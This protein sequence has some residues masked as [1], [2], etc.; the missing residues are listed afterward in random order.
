MVDRDDTGTGADRD[1]VEKLAESF[2]ERHRRGERPQISEYAEK[3]P[4][5]AGRIRELFPALLMVEQA[6]SAEIAGA[7]AA[8]APGKAEPARELGD[9]TI[10]RRIGGGGMG[11]VYEARQESLGRHV[12]LKVL[13]YQSLPAESHLERFRR[14]AQAAAQ[15]HHTNIVPVYAVGEHEGLHYYAM[16]LIQGQ[17]LE[18]VIEELRQLRAAGAAA[19][20]AQPASG[21]SI[22][23][24][25]RS[26]IFERDGD[27]GARASD[28]APQAKDGSSTAALLDGDSGAGANASIRYARSVARLGI[29]A[30]SALAYAHGEGVLHRDV[31]PSNLLLDAKGALWITDFG[32]AKTESSGALTR[33]G[34]IVGTLSYMAP[35]RL[36]GW[37]DPRSDIYALG[38]TLYELLTLTRTF[39]CPDRNR[40]MRKI[41]EEKPA[42]PRAIDPRIP[43]DLETIVLKAIEKEPARRY[44]AAAQ[45][46][47]DLRSF[48]EGRPIRARRSTTAER[49]W[50]WCRRNPV[51]GALAA[52]SVLLLLAIA[53]GAVV[54]AIRL[55]DEHNVSLEYLEKARI[56]ET[57]AAA[58]AADAKR[59]LWD[60]CLAHARA[61]RWSGRPGQRF[62]SLDALAKARALAPELG[63]G[64]ADMLKVR[65]Q[66][67][68]CFTLV[69]LRIE[70]TWEKAGRWKAAFDRAFELCADADQQGNVY[71]RRT[72][73]LSLRAELPGLGVDCLAVCMSP[74]GTHLAVRHRT[75][76]DSLWV[77]DL[78][79]RAVVL[80]S[81]IAADGYPADFSAN[82]D[83]IALGL[84]DGTVRL[85]DV[86]TGRDLE[87]IAKGPVANWIAFHPADRRLLLGNSASPTVR[88]VDPN[89]GGS[90]VRFTHERP[91]LR[92]AW[93]PG[94]MRFAAGC[95]DF[96][97]YVWDVRDNRAPRIVLAGHHAE[98]CG[99]SFGAAGNVL[100]TSSWDGTTMLWNHS[101]GR[102]LLT[103]AGRSE[104]FS[105]DGRLLHFFVGGYTRG[106]WRAAGG[107]EC[108]T[109]K[110]H[111]GDGKGCCDWVISPDER[112]LVVPCTSGVWLA[113]FATLEDAAFMPIG[114][115]W[116]AA[117]HPRSGQL[118]TSG[119]RGIHA[120][121][122]S[123]PADGGVAIGPPR[124]CA[125]L[126]LT[127][128]AVLSPDGR[129][130]AV[131]QGGAVHVISDDERIHGAVL[132]AGA[133]PIGLTMSPDGGWIAHGNWKG[134]DIRLWDVRA[135][136][137]AQRFP[138]YTGHA[139]FSPDGRWLVT[140]TGREYRLLEAGSWKERWRREREGA[141]NLPGG[142]AFSS[143]GA[144]LALAPA[145][146][147][148]LIVEPATGAEICT[149]RAPESFLFP[150]LRFCAEGRYLLA[151]DE[152][153][154]LQI[155]DLLRIRAQLRALGLDWEDAPPGGGAAQESA[156]RPPLRVTFDAGPL[157]DGPAESTP[158]AHN[159][160]MLRLCDDAIEKDPGNA[161]LRRQQEHLRGLLSKHETEQR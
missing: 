61:A 33:T 154:A 110:V 9:F 10:L 4:E 106:L 129:H 116:A 24:R 29:Q 156:R 53:I 120:W 107:L 35:E 66:A 119:D 47:A 90:E 155:W 34:D 81:P 55:R 2:I 57:Q 69:D 20:G 46:E 8:A 145:P 103:A 45:L 111:P 80:K 63:L 43:R 39:D 128:H 151:A 147:S 49:A 123:T 108:R 79:K 97:T 25:L 104:E 6:G 74:R 54:S 87:S 84:P 71:V 91:V 44:A 133:S 144:L 58:A 70:K 56:A 14:E 153:H 86:T 15:L 13:P 50:L 95:R 18:K 42:A 105:A 122:L 12:A 23:E 19:A 100:A 60:S 114:C 32:L 21:E 118:I 136:Q 135:R 76:P 52:C 157:A 150:K 31:K 137:T 41:A 83:V 85:H 36:D 126:A 73:D 125:Y 16:Q 146:G 112:L 26:G 27:A 51:S 152:S 5:L 82:G 68:S 59:Q 131:S 140:A 88:L 62:D 139:C 3:H 65:N 72:S 48:L 127:K 1:P 149:L 113:D 124:P 148:I 40:L 141:G 101:T 102:L 30:A 17:S 75:T 121:P 89:A 143:D 78:E 38:L 77:W 7:R 93:H 92:L 160:W 117:F 64:A 96:K 94:G 11:V 109:F 134:N 158:E 115:T 98:V 138:G 28:P 142:A 37:S 99:V 67:I 132:P 22:A 130:A 161:S 159:R